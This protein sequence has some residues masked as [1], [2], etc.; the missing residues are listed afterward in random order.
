MP[1]K[2]VTLDDDQYFYIMNTQEEDD[3]FSGR[4][5]E[6]VDLGIESEEEREDYPCSHCGRTFGNPG[7]RATHEQSCQEA[8]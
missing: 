2:S 6:I 3:S 5:R 7:A 8:A 4:L 1:S